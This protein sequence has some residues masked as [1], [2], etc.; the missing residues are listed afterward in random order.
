MSDPSPA[1]QPARI[2]W[3]GVAIAGGLGVAAILI[4]SLVLWAVLDPGPTGSSRGRL[5]AATATQQ[6]V[7][8]LPDSVKGWLATIF[9]GVMIL[10]GITF[11]AV[12]LYFMIKPRASAT[13][14][15][16]KRRVATWRP[17]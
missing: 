4:G 5:P 1:P 14:S 9:A 12:A 13:A 3:E 2:D 11:C 17:K 6:A 15:E 16:P 7:R 8:L 10:G